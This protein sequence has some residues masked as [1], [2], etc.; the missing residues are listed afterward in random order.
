MSL[1]S[2]LFGAKPVIKPLS[3]DEQI[4]LLQTHS[5]LE[6][7]AVID[8]DVDALLR[9]AAINRLTFSDHLKQ[10]AL[11]TTDTKLQ[12][13]ARKRIAQLLDDSVLSVVD[14]QAAIDDSR[15]L[16]AIASLSSQQS[17]QSKLLSAMTEPA[18]L[19][20]LATDGA[21]VKLRQLAAEKLQDEDLLKQLLKAT[22]GKDKGVYRIAKI[23][24]DALKTLQKQHQQLSERCGL[25][26]D[27]LQKHCERVSEPQ[28]L[29]KTQHYQEQWQ[30]L[31]AEC[32]QLEFIISTELTEEIEL[33]LKECQQQLKNQQQ[34]QQQQQE[35]HQQQLQAVAQADEE[36]DGL[37]Q[38][39]KQLLVA[40]YAADEVDDEFEQQ[41]KDELLALQKGW[42]HS[43]Q[44]KAASNIEKNQFSSIATAIEISLSRF[45]T[46]GGLLKQLAAMASAQEQEKQQRC[47]RL[48]ECLVSAELLTGQERSQLLDEALQVV[49][50]YKQLQRQAKRQL[51]DSQRQLSA[52]I[53]RAHR[54]IDA[55]HLRQ[56]RG[57]Y[58]SIEEKLEEPDSAQFNM[59][60]QFDELNAALEKL[61][62][63]QSYAVQPKMEALVEQMEALK[64]AEMP[65]D[66]LAEKIQ[67]LQADWKLFSKGSGDQF[68]E[69]WVQFNAAA[70]VAYAPC[71]IYFENLSLLREHNLKQRVVL[72]EQ[73]NQ[74]LAGHD[75][76]TADWS[77][78]EQLLRLSKSQW[79]DLSP[80]DRAAGKAS[81]QGFDQVLASIQKYLDTELD[82]NLQKK[83]L[84]LTAAEVAAASDDVRAAIETVKQL[85]VQWKAVGVVRRRDDQ[86]IWKL[87]R[88]QCDAIFDKRKQQS[89]EF[90][91]ELDAHKIVAENI[92]EQIE[93][94]LS[95]H[96]D[97]L[98][99]SRS[100]LQL[101][102][103]QFAEVGALPRASNTAIEKRFQNAVQ[104]FDA[105]CVVE[106]NAKQESRWLQLFEFSQR[107]A[108][109]ERLHQS[110]NNDQ[111]QLAM[112]TDMLESADL[113]A[114]GK[115][116][117]AQR[118]VSIGLP[119][120]EAKVEVRL[121]QLCIRMEIAAD[122][123][124]PE[125]D[126][127]LRMAYQVERLQQGLG[128]A[129]Q[130]AEDQI[131]SLVFAW[132]AERSIETELYEQLS[133]R[134][135]S[136]RLKALGLSSVSL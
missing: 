56:A 69:L 60:A 63:W 22:K 120:D 37:L 3:L 4:E 8:S 28:F 72:V 16:L 103:T 34:Q 47:Q 15:A 49:A 130:P 111:A 108:E 105:R 14:M 41:Q 85:Q 112:L 43:V 76:S 6:L 102:K 98:L 104:Q 48:S 110:G 53:R 31:Q 84:L 135:M 62:D 94:L 97:E 126:Q 83:Q 75:W 117:L 25:L 27:G 59:A 109:C 119:F 68:Q 107:I 21:S 114:E 131:E 134:L 52:L 77:A 124:T 11:Q 23:K 70:Q 89:E 128:Q 129:N 55:G 82:N 45:K 42:Q 44:L 133:A 93:A 29:A 18:V 116:V 123:S 101:L 12:G 50:E 5:E 61:A 88:S 67:R 26:R 32:Q 13:A 40:I 132:L 78:V 113:V 1:F 20:E 46:N 2:R 17:L 64:D 115:K 87:F 125:S 54:A 118:I 65:A 91:V 106:K 39:A 79:R 66:V 99:S 10:L 86:K 136:A 51:Q 96:G 73:L 38:S 19:F 24:C 7:A 71:K 92:I 57:I 95:L 81:Q 74:Y 35:F 30:H 122:I 127:A 33:L 58:R 100:A 36:R 9:L 80:V 121:R 90:K